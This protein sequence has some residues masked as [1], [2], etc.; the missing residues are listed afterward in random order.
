MQNNLGT[1]Y[2][3]RV[4][5]VRKKNLKKAMA[6]FN[7]ALTVHTSENFPLDARRAARNLGNLLFEKGRWNEAHIAYGK[8]IKAAKSLYLAAFTEAG[9]EAEIGENAALYT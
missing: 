7:N 3:E 1:A 8:A 2:W 4:R 6:C 9:R 5:G